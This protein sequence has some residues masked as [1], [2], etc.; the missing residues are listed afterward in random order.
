[1]TIDDVIRQHGEA[2]AKE[3]VEDLIGEMVDDC[4]NALPGDDYPAPRT[5]AEEAI[6][7]EAMRYWERELIKSLRKY[8]EDTAYDITRSSPA[9]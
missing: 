6:A 5:D 9:T 8:V 4:H 1:M 2:A 3:L 7:E